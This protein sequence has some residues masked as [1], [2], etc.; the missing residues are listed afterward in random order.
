MKA[1]I[2]AVGLGKP[3]ARIFPN[4][5]VER[6]IF[7]HLYVKASFVLAVATSYNVRLFT[8]AF[9][10]NEILMKYTDLETNLD[11]ETLINK[12]RIVLNFK[13]SK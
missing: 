6:F 1:T 3:I 12:V 2:R 10:Q 11:D 13:F 7:N 8:L 4:Q 9:T 5:D